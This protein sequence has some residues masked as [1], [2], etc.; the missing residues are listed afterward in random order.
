MIFR[1]LITETRVVPW[2]NLSIQPSPPPYPCR[3]SQEGVYKSAEGKRLGGVA[4]YLACSFGGLLC[5]IVI[6]GV[7]PDVRGG[8]RRE[9]L[10]RG[11]CGTVRAVMGGWNEA[12][13]NS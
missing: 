8:R 1:N 4:G 6:C 7:R 2:C 10:Q 11:K 9:A 5:R 12:E 13:A 3:K